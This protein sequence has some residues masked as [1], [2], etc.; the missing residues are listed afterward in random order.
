M[1]DLNNYQKSILIV[2]VVMALIFA[3]LYPKT[4]SK[5]GYLYEDTILVPTQQDGA[6]VYAGKIQGQQAQFTVRDQTVSFRYGDKDYGEYTLQ[7]VP[8]AVPKENGAASSM[9]GVV[10]RHNGEI[11]FRGGVL[12]SRLG[13]SFYNEDG[14]SLYSVIVTTSN[15]VTMDENG[16]VIDQMEPTVRMIY[17]LLN[18]PELTHK[19]NGFFW[20]LGALVCGINALYIFFAEELFYFKMSF[21]VRDAEL[22]EPSEW[23]VATRYIGWTVM[24]LAALYIFA[25]G[26]QQIA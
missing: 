21:R 5:V 22:A 16:K 18:E 1:E 9:T 26:L 12:E 3:F 23:E 20:F 19:G 25:V 4:I 10:I 14:S 8:E 13:R 2:M 24:V 6:T 17:E 11:F 7:Y 15:G